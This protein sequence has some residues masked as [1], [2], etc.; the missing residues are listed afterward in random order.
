MAHD[1]HNTR[2]M[3]ISDIDFS[4][5]DYELPARYKKLIWPRTKES[6]FF[7]KSASIGNANN[8]NGQTSQP[9]RNGIRIG[10]SSVKAI[11]DG[12]DQTS[13]HGE[14]RIENATVNQAHGSSTNS[15]A[16]AFHSSL[17]QIKRPHTTFNPLSAPFIPGRLST[18]KVDQNDNDNVCHHDIVAC[19][20]SSMT[21]T[22]QQPIESFLSLTQNPAHTSAPS[23]PGTQE[24]NQYPNY[25]FSPYL[26]WSNEPVLWTESLRNPVPQHQQGSFCDGAFLPAHNSTH[27][28]LEG[29]PQLDT[30][31]ARLVPGG[32]GA[33]SNKSEPEY[34]Q[35][36]GVWH[37]FEADPS[38]F[39]PGP[40]SLSGCTAN[41]PFK[42]HGELSR[43]Y[44]IANHPCAFHEALAAHFYTQTSSPTLTSQV[45][46][47]PFDGFGRD[48]NN[49]AF[50]PLWGGN[51]TTANEC[52]PS[53]GFHG[54]QA[55]PR[56]PN[57][58]TVTGFPPQHAFDRPTLQ[59]PKPWRPAETSRILTL[60]HPEHYSPLAFDVRDMDEVV[61]HWWAEID[62][63][64]PAD[65]D[66]CWY[67]INSRGSANKPSPPL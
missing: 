34:R 40:V 29:A 8:N 50:P 37:D 67:D 15:I 18:P 4:T 53:A 20:T 54:G 48:E 9:N 56:V 22:G 24:H 38:T 39:S 63:S 66:S 6:R 25:V 26:L 46:V 59:A 32:L 61:R 7:P 33:Q 23:I 1:T 17:T 28:G 44:D 64:E 41:C 47:P 58:E 16:T 65:T 13:Q 42:F 12:H 35:K 49:E 3:K 57:P 2:K 45:L 51:H 21:D 31:N 36:H 10:T 27:H 11:L 60:D 62:Y 5:C 30:F 43:D 19:V 52:S 55:P 14:N